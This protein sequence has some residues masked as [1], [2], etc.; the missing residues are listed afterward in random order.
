MFK[1]LEDLRKK[2]FNFQWLKN[3]TKFIL[4]F[5]RK[6]KW[7]CWIAYL[8]IYTYYIPTIYTYYIHNLYIIELSLMKRKW[9]FFLY[10]DFFFLFKALLKWVHAT[11]QHSNESRLIGKDPDS[12]KDWGQEEKGTIKDDMVGWHHQFNGWAISRDNEGQRTLA[13]CNS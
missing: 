8:H 2:L 3:V 7:G 4:W 9:N 12:R 13:S 6:S 5:I 1:V 11:F 10:P